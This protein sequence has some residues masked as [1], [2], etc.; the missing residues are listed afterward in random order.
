MHQLQANVQVISMC[1]SSQV[2]I[3][4]VGIPLTMVVHSVVLTVT[5]HRLLTSKPTKEHGKITDGR[6]MVARE[7]HQVPTKIRISTNTRYD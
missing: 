1:N 6:R 7:G 4:V 3:R 5:A 2:R